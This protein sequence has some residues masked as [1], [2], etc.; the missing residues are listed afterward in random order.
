MVTWGHL[1]PTLGHFEH[2][3]CHLGGH[4]GVTLAHLVDTLKPGAH[5]EPLCSWNATF[6]SVILIQEGNHWFEFKDPIRSKKG[7][8]PPDRCHFCEREAVLITKNS[9]FYC[10]KTNDS[11]I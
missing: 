7:G 9:L 5:F 6:C 3:L 11:V 4:L 1:G 10:R 8:Q 2:T